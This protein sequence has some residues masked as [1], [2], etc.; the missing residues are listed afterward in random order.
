MLSALSAFDTPGRGTFCNIS[1]EKLVESL[2]EST[3]HFAIFQYA[4]RGN[5]EYKYEKIVKGD[6]FPIGCV[7]DLMLCCV[8]ELI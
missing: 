5:S 6:F 3:Y 8:K 1:Y 2:K 4:C 7:K